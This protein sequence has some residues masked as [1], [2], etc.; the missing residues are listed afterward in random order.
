MWQNYVPDNFSN[1][2]EEVY[3]PCCIQA[4]NRRESELF[5][6]GARFRKGFFHIKLNISKDGEV[7]QG[8]LT[9][10]N[11]SLTEFVCLVTVSL[12]HI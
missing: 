5:S 4:S 2:E 10:M 11:L 1:T 6:S 8:K 3:E 12:W 9:H 7:E